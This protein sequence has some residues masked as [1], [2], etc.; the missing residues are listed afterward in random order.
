MFSNP[1]NK[2]FVRQVIS[3]LRPRTWSLRTRL[4]GTLVTLLA[5]VCL[6]VGAVTATA[7][8]TYLIGQIDD[9]LEAVF[10]RSPGQFDAPGPGRPPPDPYQRPNSLGASIVG[11]R[12]LFAQV[13]NENGDF[14]TL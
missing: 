3:P 8:R 14:V 5:L 12:V 9:Q 13:L 6:V 7:L 1:L 4:I 2:R 10:V 11:H